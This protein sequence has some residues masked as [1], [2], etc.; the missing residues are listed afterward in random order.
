MSIFHLPRVDSD[1]NP[2]LMKDPTS[3]VT[4]SYRFRY[5]H[6]WHSHL[7]FYSLVQSTWNSFKYSGSP[8]SEKLS[9]LASELHSW[10]RLNFNNLARN[11]EVL[12]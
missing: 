6:V 4:R 5:E 9:I 3:G 1:H 10:S 8:F 7:C 11:V 2:L 12:K